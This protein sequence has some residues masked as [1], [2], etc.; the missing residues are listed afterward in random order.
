MSHALYHRQS[1]GLGYDFE[2]V[3]CLSIHLDR[4]YASVVIA[5]RI[6]LWLLS[7]VSWVLCVRTLLMPGAL[8]AGSH[9][10]RTGNETGI[11]SARSCHC[12]V[13]L[14]VVWLSVSIARI[15]VL[16]VSICSFDLFLYFVLVYVLSNESFV[17]ALFVV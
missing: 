7:V 9:T 12:S 16:L 6:L 2:G 4:V 10:D 3:V 14:V 1:L 13:G 11:V 15:V 17:V 8:D 5:H